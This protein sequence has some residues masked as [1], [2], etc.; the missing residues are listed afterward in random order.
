ME[1]FHRVLLKAKQ[2]YNV[3]VA[4]EVVACAALK[5]PTYL[6]NVKVALVQERERLFNLLKYVPFLDPYPIYSNFILCKVK[7]GMDAKKLKVSNRG[8]ELDPELV[9]RIG[10]QDLVSQNN[11]KFRVWRLKYEERYAKDIDMWIH[12]ATKLA[13][14][15]EFI[16]RI[17]LNFNQR[18]EF[19]QFGYRNS[20]LKK[21]YLWQ[22]QLN[23]IGSSV[24]WSSLISL[25]IGFVELAD[26]VM[27]KVLSGCPNLEDLNLE[28]VSGINRLEIS[29]EKLRTLLLE[30]YDDSLLEII[31]PHI[32]TL[33]ICGPC[34]EIRIGQR[35][36]ASLVNAMLHAEF[37]SEESYL[38]E[39]LQSVVHAETLNLGSWCIECL[40]I[41]ELEGWQFP[42][43]SPKVLTL[44]VA[45]GQLDF[46]GI[47]S[48]LQSSLDLETLVIE[49]YDNRETLRLL[50][51]NQLVG[52][53]IPD[54]ILQDLL[55]RLNEDEQTRRFET[56][57]FNGSF[58]HLKTIKFCNF[59][60]SV[61]PLVKYL[62]KHAIVLEEFSIDAAFQESDASPGYEI[63]AL[64]F[65]SL[66]R[67]SPHA[68]VLFSY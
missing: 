3:F 61:L 58:P 5:N 25:S 31:A 24:N 21:L 39:L 35:N 34:S 52:F 42:P 26:D 4:A 17:F 47:C 40:S 68:R 18:Y 56:H 20:S 50:I 63:M 10:T 1:L 59:Y 29:S 36:V 62:L 14:V 51:H 11:P 13:N 48:F 57:N 16:L 60:G 53:L 38:K 6:E 43:S 30:N 64:D 45:F 7:S 15:E 55:S 9:A 23:P 46:P 65:L 41:L 33:Q 8:W 44:G 32:E 12:F 27:E 37:E 66:T 2:P 19:P 49:W 67:S 22:C 54:S 28:S